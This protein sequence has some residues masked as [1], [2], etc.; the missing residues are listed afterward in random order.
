MQFKR[1]H[2]ITGNDP[3]LNRRIASIFLSELESFRK[4]LDA[5]I[6]DGNKE[7]L[8]SMIFKLSPSFIIFEKD[9]LVK[10]LESIAD[11]NNHEQ[12]EGIQKELDAL[13]EALAQ[14]LASL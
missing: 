2:N 11:I 5:Y 8:K 12:L 9:L 13:H 7:D 14:F 6:K 10:Q 1:L 4:N 3:A